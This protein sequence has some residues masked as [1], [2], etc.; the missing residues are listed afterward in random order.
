MGNKKN[1]H[2]YLVRK[3]AHEVWPVKTYFERQLPSSRPSASCFPRLALT[4]LCAKGHPTAA[5]A[6]GR[7]PDSSRTRVASSVNWDRS[8]RETQFALS[9]E[10]AKK[11]VGE[12]LC[13]TNQGKMVRLRAIRQPFL[14]DIWF[15]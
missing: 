4:A 2:S 6:P 1:P 12:A 8:V 14:G 11:H 7:P 5:S 10:S 13:Q 15:F 3:I 9:R